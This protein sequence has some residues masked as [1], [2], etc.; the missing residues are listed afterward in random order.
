MKLRK[1]FE[2]IGL[3]FITTGTCCSTIFNGKVG[4]I[5]LLLGLIIYGWSFAVYLIQNTTD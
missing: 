2:K 3:C 5:L 1:L 4:P